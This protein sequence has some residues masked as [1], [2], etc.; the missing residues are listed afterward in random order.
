MSFN[1]CWILH[2]AIIIPK[3]FSISYKITKN[4]NDKLACSSFSIFRGQ[5]YILRFQKMI[6]SFQPL[7][8]YDAA[9]SHK[10]GKFVWASIDDS[11]VTDHK[12]AFKY[13]NYI[14]A[15]QKGNIKKFRKYLHCFFLSRLILHP[16][17]GSGFVQFLFG[18]RF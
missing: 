4:E 9:T 12:V 15:V 10:T 14:W 1:L 13:G 6:S 8:S 3:K 16:F 11:D 7:L 17:M 5:R 2:I 18:L